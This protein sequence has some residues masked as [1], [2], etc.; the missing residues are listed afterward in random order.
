[1]CVVGRRNGEGRRCLG[2][3][4]Q[5]PPS[6]W[7]KGRSQGGAQSGWGAVRG[8]GGGQLSPK[9]YIKGQGG[10]AVMRSSTMQGGWGGAVTG[11]PTA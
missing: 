7:G 2:E 10:F 1:M 9:K 3:G 8:E 5:W 4:G 11:T 6:L